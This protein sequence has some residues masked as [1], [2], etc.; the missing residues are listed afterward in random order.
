VLFLPVGLQALTVPELNQVA[1]DLGARMIIPVT[2]KTDESGI[3]PLR[4]LDDYLAET[5]FPVR[6]LDT[7]EIVVTHDSLPDRPTVYALKSPSGL[8]TPPPPPTP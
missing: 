4:S 6:K 8:A 3:L 2:Y 5:S 1:T 7:D